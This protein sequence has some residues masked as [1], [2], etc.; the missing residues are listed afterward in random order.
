MKSFLIWTQGALVLAILVAGCRQPDT[1]R[2]SD[3]RTPL[4]IVQQFTNLLATGSAPNRM[5][6]VRALG[7]LSLESW[8]QLSQATAVDALLQVS[9]AADT[10]L[11]KLASQALTQLAGSKKVTSWSP[12]VISNCAV[13]GLNSVKP[14]IQCTAAAMLLRQFPQNMAAKTRLFA[15]LEHAEPAIRSQAGSALLKES[16]DN[17]ALKAELHSRLLGLMN[18][19]NHAMRLETISLLCNL[20]WGDSASSGDAASS[21]LRVDA[22][23][24]LVG[25]L[26]SPDVK[27]RRTGASL[28]LVGNAPV[29]IRLRET[30][31]ARLEDSDLQVAVPM[32]FL[33]NPTE[34][35]SG[36]SRQAIPGTLEVLRRGLL[37]PDPR[38]R[39]TALTPMSAHRWWIT[40]KQT[41][42]TNFSGV[43]E[44]FSVQNSAAPLV[45][46]PLTNA[47]A[48]PDWLVRLQAASMVSVLKELRELHSAR[49]WQIATEGLASADPEVQQRALWLSSG[50]S[51]WL[52]KESAVPPEKFGEEFRAALT[53]T[54]AMVRRSALD[55]AGY[56]TRR[57][58]RSSLESWSARCSDPDPAVRADA[59]EYLAVVAKEQGRGTNPPWVTLPAG[60]LR[61]VADPFPQV[62]LAGLAVL[63]HVATATNSGPAA[64]EARQRLKEIASGADP[65]TKARLARVYQG[66]AL[67]N[68]LVDVS[69][70]SAEAEQLLQTLAA[71]PEA[72][73]RRQAVLGLNNLGISL[74]PQIANDPDPEV[75]RAAA[76]P[77]EPQPGNTRTVPDAFEV[78]LGRLRTNSMSIRRTAAL[79]L[80][81]HQ[82]LQ[83]RPGLQAE[84]LNT[85]LQTYAGPTTADFQRMN[86]AILSLCFSGN[87]MAGR[88]QQVQAGACWLSCRMDRHRISTAHP[89]LD[90]R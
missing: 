18:T 40:L 31:V 51:S 55:H 77:A 15:F 50:L 53:S 73:V 4:G 90:W 65:Y 46:Q 13:R 8:D 72:V 7:S 81:S 82:Q 84:V 85:L 2:L 5:A 6:A 62:S 54:N 63:H 89:R 71:A 21:G 23:Q 83:Q 43:R 32:A 74:P 26:T 24:A 56:P 61:L 38:V 86:Q 66:R 58:F 57:R 1:F 88:Q 70:P 67:P 42:T 59:G 12:E 41:V 3:D 68:Y 64:L 33:L 78:L 37:D 45:L 76:M 27:E 35:Y 16:R 80:S 28:A 52:S 47:L 60:V 9:G 20:A 22:E 39:L 87:E 19:T 49:L 29:T 30:A 25:L 69:S 34:Y 17:G 75:S 48:D 44:T 79:Q 36:D 10:N 11:Q 14:S